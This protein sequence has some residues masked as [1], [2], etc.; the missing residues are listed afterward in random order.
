MGFCPSCGYEY[1][2]GI[3]ICPDCNVELVEKLPEEP[4]FYEENWVALRNL[5]G[6]IYAEMVKEVLDKEKIP[7][8]IKTD[9]VSSA[10]V[11]SSVSTAGSSA[12]IFVPEKFLSKAK[13]I[14]LEMMDH[15]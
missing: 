7:S 9:S 8:F 15:I 4:E 11:T 14:L 5:P 12:T 6:N 10:L 13:Q 1:L 3:K 2:Q